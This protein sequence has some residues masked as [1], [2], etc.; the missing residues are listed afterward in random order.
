MFPF[1]C[2]FNVFHQCLI[3]YPPPGSICIPFD[4][5]E[6]GIVLIPLSA[7]LFLLYRNAIGF[8]I[9]ILYPATLLDL[10]INFNGVLVKSLGSSI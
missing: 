3:V 9:L 6:N 5:I 1:T 8:Y 2:V 4:A 7:T 10:L